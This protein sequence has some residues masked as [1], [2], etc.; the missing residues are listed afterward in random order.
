ME[1]RVTNLISITN[2]E[3][4]VSVSFKLRS[5]DLV[6]LEVRTIYTIAWS[7]YGRFTR[8]GLV[9]RF[10]LGWKP[11]EHIWTRTVTYVAVNFYSRFRFVFFF[12]RVYF[13]TLL[14]CCVEIFINLIFVTSA[15]V[16][17]LV[18]RSCM[19]CAIEIASN[20]FTMLF[21]ELTFIAFYSF[22]ILYTIFICNRYGMLCHRV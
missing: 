4:V 15:N 17:C 12:F 16:S 3:R 13:V 19:R 10:Y 9:F 1:V 6:D 18:A 5:I 20:C 7:T 11:Y 2:S 8:W 22:D 14:R 21:V